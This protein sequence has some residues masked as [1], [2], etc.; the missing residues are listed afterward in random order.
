VRIF[1]VFTMLKYYLVLLGV[2][3]LCI[4]C[5]SSAEKKA[6]QKR[7]DDS[8]KQLR[9]KDS[10]KKIE[11]DQIKNLNTPSNLEVTIEQKLK[12]GG[13]FLRWLQKVPELQKRIT[14]QEEQ[15]TLFIPSDSAFK[16]FLS[17]KRIDSTNT[18]Q[19]QKVLEN[20]IISAYLPLIDLMS[21]NEVTTLSQKKLSVQVKDKKIYIGNIKV[22]HSDIQYHSG[23]LHT[24]D[25]VIF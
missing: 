15:Y 19:V 22:L 17:A 9:V 18:A 21:S 10:L 24:I 14:N 12:T 20:H 7:I 25:Q 6:R 2:F 8:L 5:G 13:H 16:V 11:E 4:S 1:I 3:L 23:I